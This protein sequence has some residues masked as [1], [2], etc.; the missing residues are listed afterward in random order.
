[1]TLVRSIFLALAVMLPTAWTVAQAAD[2]PRRRGRWRRQEGEEGQ[3]GQEGRGRRGREEGGRQGRQVI[4]LAVAGPFGLRLQLKTPG[5]RE[6]TGGFFYSRSGRARTPLWST[7][8]RR[9]RLAGHA[10]ATLAASAAGRLARAAVTTLPPA[11]A[12]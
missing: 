9:L 6:R 7:A 10:V 11:A 5:L 3:E 2:A 12:M 1:M 4:P 8:P